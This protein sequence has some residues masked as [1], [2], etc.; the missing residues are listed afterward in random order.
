[1]RLYKYQ[2]NMVEATHQ[3]LTNGIGRQLL[4]LATGGGKTIVAADLINTF[5][6]LDKFTLFIVHR[7]SLI[8][9]T[10]DKFAA[11]KLMVSGCSGNHYPDILS[12]CVVATWQSLK[13]TGQPR[14]G[15]IQKPDGRWVFWFNSTQ[16]K[17][18]DVLILDEAHQ[19][20]YVDKLQ[21]LIPKHRQF[22]RRTE[23]WMHPKKEYWFYEQN[24]PREADSII[25][26]GLTATPWRLKSKEFL[27]DYFDEQVL[28]ATVYELQLKKRLSPAQYKSIDPPTSLAA[29]RIR[30]GDYIEAEM[31][32]AYCTPAALEK[33]IT[34]YLEHASTRQSIVFCSTCAP[35][36]FGGER[37][38]KS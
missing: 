6:G 35:R 22:I 9:Q 24:S 11:I 17:P 27:S 14:K 28:G 12:S 20:T 18:I 4:T 26:I 3:N 2:K 34:A 30:M 7:T 23:D 38:P 15:L 13:L 8:Q 1:M 16:Y 31:E 37:T 36:P 25:T 29:L 5:S 21:A 33:F 19:T 10:L 32:S